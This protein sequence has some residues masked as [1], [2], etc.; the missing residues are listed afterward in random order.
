MVGYQLDDFKSLH[1]K[2]LF[3]HFHPFQKTG[4]L[5]FQVRFWG[6]TPMLHCTM[7]MAGRASSRFTC[8]W[9]FLGS[10]PSRE[11]TPHHLLGF[12]SSNAPKKNILYWW[13]VMFIPGSLWWPLFC[14]KFGP[15]FGRFNP[16]NNSKLGGGFL[17]NPASKN[18]F[19]IGNP[20]SPNLQS[21]NT[22]LQPPPSKSVGVS[23]L[24]RKI[25]SNS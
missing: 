2:W 13:L 22:F 18:M 11:I 7:L 6:D 12:A 5:G 19:R 23:H 25:T 20:I 17:A 15:C 3:H 16:Q 1:G 21:K 9:D 24:S 4:C 8:R 10:L 14:L